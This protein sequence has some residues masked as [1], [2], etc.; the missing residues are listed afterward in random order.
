MDSSDHTPAAAAPAAAATVPSSTLNG[1]DSHNDAAVT[2]TTAATT[3]STDA[4][5]VDSASSSSSSTSSSTTAAA[6]GVVDDGVPLVV[7][8]IATIGYTVGT[9]EWIDEEKLA[10]PLKDAPTDI[11][12]CIDARKEKVKNDFLQKQDQL[13][14]DDKQFIRDTKERKK[15]QGKKALWALTWCDEQ[16]RKVRARAFELLFLPCIWINVS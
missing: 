11:S 2:T 14:D 6:A 16:K 1:G 4:S 15:R 10:R 12:I 8:R 9:G 3:S 7:T 13:S 5:T